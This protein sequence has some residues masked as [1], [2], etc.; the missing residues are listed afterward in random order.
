MGLMSVNLKIVLVNPLGTPIV[1]N[2]ILT[3]NPLYI[4]HNTGHLTRTVGSPHT[5]QSSNRHQLDAV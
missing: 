1:G 2:S 3:A 5:K 4:L